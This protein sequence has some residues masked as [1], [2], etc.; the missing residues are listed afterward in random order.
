MA[1][2]MSP[3][4]YKG[5][6]LGQSFLPLF[7]LD[8]LLTA[9]PMPCL[10]ERPNGRMVHGNS[11]SSVKT[12]DYGY[13]NVEQSK[14]TSSRLRSPAG[15]LLFSNPWSLITRVIRTPSI[16]RSKMPLQ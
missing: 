13:R 14:G 5:E 2:P 1:S 11:H 10:R 15:F 16:S 8:Y 12:T 9:H 4:R 6:S 7:F 3:G